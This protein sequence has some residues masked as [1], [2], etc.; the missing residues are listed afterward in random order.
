LAVVCGGCGERFDSSA[1]DESG[2][3]A[4]CVGAEEGDGGD[5]FADAFAVEL[6][7]LELS[8]V[9]PTVRAIGVGVLRAQRTLGLL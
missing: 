5:E 2:W 6:R 8:A 1:L 9:D 4:A 3:C 7:A